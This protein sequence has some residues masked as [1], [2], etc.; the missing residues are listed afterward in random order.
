QINPHDKCP[1]RGAGSTEGV[2]MPPFLPRKRL[3]SDSPNLEREPEPKPEAPKPKRNRTGNLDKT[4]TGETSRK[5]NAAIAPPRKRT[6]FDDLDTGAQHSSPR[7]PSELLRSL[8]GEEDDEE[9]NSEDLE[10]EDV[11]AGEDEDDD[12]DVEFE[13]IPQAGPTNIN[14]PSMSAAPAEQEDLDLTLTRETRISLVNPHNKKQ[15]PSKIE[16][17]IRVATHQMHVQFLMWHN[18]IRN[19][20]CCDKELQDI[21]TGELMKRTSIEKDLKRWKRDSGLGVDEKPK[22]KG[23]P[24]EENENK[25]KVEKGKERSQTDWSSYAQRAEIGSVNMSH[26]DPLFSLLNRLSSYW[27][28]RFTIT[29]P[30]LKKMGYMTLPRIDEEIKSNRA[31]YDLERHGERI[32]NKDSFKELAKEHAGS[33]DVGAQLFTALLRGLGLETRMVV[34]LQPVGFGWSKAEEAVER[35]EKKV[36]SKEPDLPSSDESDDDGSTPSIKGKAA[37]KSKQ[38]L[39]RPKEAKAI[40]HVSGKSRRGKGTKDIPIDLSEEEQNDD[41]G[42]NGESDGVG[43]DASPNRRQRKQ[44]SKIYEKDLAPNYWIEVLSPVTNIW[45]PVNPFAPSDPVATNP[46][47]LLGF[48]PRGAKAEKARQVM[49]YIIG[50]SSDG[51]AK[52]VTVRYLKRHMWPGKTKGVRMPVEKVPVY[53]SNG[54]IKRHEEYDWFKTVMSGYERRDQQRS[55]IDDQEEATDLKAVKPEKKEAKDGEETLQSYKQ[56]SE[57]VLQRHLRREEALLPTAK[58]IKLFTVKGK[59]DAPAIEEKVY[60]RKDVVNCKSVETWHKEGREPKVGEQP[61]KRVPY[62]AATTNRKRELAEAELASGGEKILQGLY[63]RDQTDWI[64]PPPVED[65]II[66]KNAFGNMDCYVPSMVPKGAVHIPL[67]GTTR[68]CRK[69]GIDFAEAVTGFEFGARMAI[70]IIS[71][72]IVAEE[73]EEMV[74]EHWREYEAERLRKEDDKRTKAALGL[75]RKF[76][77][78]MRIMKRVREE[79]GEHGGENPDALNPWTNKN[80]MDDARANAEGDVAMQQIAQADE[81]MAGGFFPEGHGEEEVPQGFFPTRHEDSED[82]GGG[83]VIERE[84]PDK[85]PTRNISNTYPTPLSIQQNRLS[86]NTIDVSDGAGSFPSSKPI[87]PT[88]KGATRSTARLSTRSNLMGGDNMSGPDS[89]TEGQP[90]SDQRSSGRHSLRRG[91]PGKQVPSSDGEE[92]A[93]PDLDNVY[94]ARDVH[95]PAAKTPASRKKGKSSKLP[96]ESPATRAMPKRKATRRSTGTKSQYFEAD[97]EDDFECDVAQMSK[98]R[99]SDYQWPSRAPRS[100]T[101]PVRFDLDTERETDRRRAERSLRGSRDVS[102]FVDEDYAFTSGRSR[103]GRDRF[104]ERN[105]GERTRSLSPKFT[106]EPIAS[107]NSDIIITAG[108]DSNDEYG[109]PA[110]TYRR[111]RSSAY[112]PSRFDEKESSHYQRPRKRRLNLSRFLGQ[113]RDSLEGT[114]S[115]ST[116]DSD[117]SDDAYSFTLTRHKRSTSGIE[118]VSD[119]TSEASE[120]DVGGMEPEKMISQSLLAPKI[121]N[122]FDSRYTG[123]GSV[124]GVQSARIT[125]LPTPP[126]NHGQKKNRPPLFKWIHFEDAAMNFDDYQNGVAAVSGLSDLERQAISRL[127]ARVGKRFDKPFQTSNGMKA[128][129]LIPSLTAENIVNQTGSKTSKPRVVTW[130]SLP[131]FTLQKY[132]AGPATARPADHP[133]RSLMQA[134]FSLVQRGRDMQQAVCHLLDTPDDYCFH[135]AQTWYLILDDSLLITC[136]GIRMSSLQGDGIKIVPEPSSKHP[137]NWPPCILVSSGRCLLWC[138]KV[139][140]CQTWFDFVLLFGEFWPRRLEFKHNGKIIRAADWPRIIAQAKKTNVRLTVDHRATLRDKFEAPDNFI[141]VTRD[142]GKTVSASKPTVTSKAQPG[143]S[144]PSGIPGFVIHEYDK[145]LKQNLPGPPSDK[146]LQQGV[147]PAGAESPP[148]KA[149]DTSTDGYFDKLKSKPSGSARPEDSLNLPGVQNSALK[150]DNIFNG[151]Y[152]FAWLNSHPTA[153]LSP[154]LFASPLERSQS[155][156][157]RSSSSPSGS[158]ED[159]TTPKATPEIHWRIEEEGIRDDLREVDDFLKNRSSVSDRI[160]YQECALGSRDSIVEQLTRVK[161]KLMSAEKVNP[162]KLKILGTKEAIAAAAD[163]IF[164]F[165]LPITFEG[166]TVQKY[167]GAIDSL[168]LPDK[169]QKPKAPENT[170]QYYPGRQFYPKERR[171][172]NFGCHNEEVPY[173]AEFLGQIARQI[174]PFKEFYAEAL[175]ADRLN[176]RLPEEFP[177]AWLYLLISVASTTKDMAVFDNQSPVVHDLLDKGMRK[178]VQ[179][180]SKKSLLDSLVFTPFELATL[181][182]FQLLEGATPYSQDIVEPYWQY[183]RSLEADIAANPVDRNHQDRIALF[184]Q[185]IYVINDTLSQQ[186]RLLMLASPSASFRNGAANFQNNHLNKV[187]NDDHRSVVPGV[188][189]QPTVHGFNNLTPHTRYDT[190]NMEPLDV[191]IVVDNHGRSRTSQLAPTHPNG[192]LGILIYDAISLVDHKLRDIREMHDWVS[193]LQASNLQKIDTNK[194]RQEAAI[195]AFTIVTIVFLPLSTVAGIMGMNTVDIRDMELSQWVFWA[196]AIPLMVVVITLCLIWAGELGNFWKG[197]RDMWRRRDRTRRKKVWNAASNFTPTMAYSPMERSSM[198]NTGTDSVRDLDHHSVGVRNR[199]RPEYLGGL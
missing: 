81:D 106:E 48:E 95:I 110:H 139:D 64:I 91:G 40:S 191:P 105:I 9:S 144:N 44:P 69:L 65:G 189:T 63:S 123:E 108:P 188:Y 99:L 159:S 120:G 127:L 165:F 13:D 135:I 93:G 143:T 142:F 98:E 138:F 153:M 158:R 185:E 27:K 132:K 18:S 20:W 104:L 30:G 151:F 83:F 176:I 133:I 82:D 163:Q 26:G 38:R 154:P 42:D 140:E 55:I 73:N 39:T 90:C 184:K 5:S 32:E 141:P 14:R 156:R 50:F 61:L 183:L 8:G 111:R 45:V 4:Q 160:V 109:D 47:L 124:G 134:R 115:S 146:E 145:P 128:K 79:Y 181:I 180:T 112:S 28:K 172:R 62:R 150:P 130:M 71:G 57:F 167:W 87:A 187:A 3:R 80:T 29:T 78:G 199:N 37:I 2:V 89:D 178:V 147:K 52:D 35:K 54:K 1:T 86:Q 11:A 60:P 36:R 196:A 117:V 174:Q 12:D 84:Q 66:P 148:K 161:T 25:K 168:I 19:R 46:E 74:I 129:F 195:Y 23:N 166:P 97:D 190:A 173:I 177:K 22:R 31:E 49:A 149:S 131:H 171:K 186:R 122:V 34:S 43:V 101:R 157:N 164:Q 170:S 76:L 107:D 53:N 116:S 194:D 198:Y 6:L 119:A 192:V 59:A 155:S 125:V 102:G 92:I 15:G 16:R 113:R 17:E 72:V 58:H 21:L 179:E 197:F 77:M 137:G 7:T 51:T 182:N 41:N 75:W 85:K 162:E 33:R 94:E 67:R 136:A 175:P 96:V 68:I 118:I 24:K 114:V 100:D 169:S 152:V 70:P 10:F 103:L 126:Q 88:K 56:S 193:H 121:Q